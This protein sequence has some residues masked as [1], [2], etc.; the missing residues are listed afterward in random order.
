MNSSEVVSCM[1]VMSGAY[2]S[3]TITDEMVL[4]WANAFDHTSAHLVINALHLWIQG[5]EWPPT[6]AGIR[7]KMRDLAQ[8]QARELAWTSRA[9][10]NEV[11]LTFAEGRSVAAASYATDCAERG[12]EPSWAYFDRAIGGS[13][14]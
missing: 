9:A 4:L 6:I 5:E 14:K 1:S 13:K 8:A 11:Y 12:V 2:P 10:P 7:N 3:L